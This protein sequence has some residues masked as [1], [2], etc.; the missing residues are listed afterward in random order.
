MLM[1]SGSISGPSDMVAFTAGVFSRFLAPLLLQQGRARRSTDPRGP[2]RRAP[3]RAGVLH[4][5]PLLLADRA[6][7]GRER[8]RAPPGALPPG[9]P[10]APETGIPDALDCKQIWLGERRRDERR[11]SDYLRT[12]LKRRLAGKEPV[13]LHFEAQFHRPEPGDTLDWYNSGVDWPCDG[14]PWL[15]V[16]VVTLTAPSP[17]RRPSTCGSTPATTPP[18]WASRRRTA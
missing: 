11:P 8:P 13:T 10:V 7:L 1:N 18:A 15:T 4:D 6:L 9:E 5:G 3:P 17:T 14:H 12:A 16:A 2:D